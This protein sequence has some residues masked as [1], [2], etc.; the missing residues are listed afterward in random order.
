MILI[1]LCVLRDFVVQSDLLRSRLCVRISYAIAFLVAD[2]AVCRT[3]RGCPEC[4]ADSSPTTKGQ[5]AG[6]YGNPVIKT[7][8]LDALA[9][10]GDA[11][12]VCLLHHGQLQPQ[13]VGD[14]YRPVQSCER[15]V[16]PGA[17]RTS[18]SAASTNVKSLPV[19]LSAAGY[20]TARIGKFH[21]GPDSVYRFD[22][23]LPGNPRNPV[24][25]AERLP[26]I[27]RSASRTSRSFCT[28]AR[29]IRIAAAARPMRLPSDRT[30][31][32]TSRAAS[33]IR[34]SSRC[35]TSRRT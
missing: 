17:R 27:D 8:N 14:S 2:I 16:R 22:E 15:P 21:V 12:Q 19:L 4:G 28:S 18:L 1:S 11:V 6:C 33:R 26:R 32:A 7:P 25:M 20:R 31:S 30:A 24:A 35:I 10:D 34:A 9:A 3:H 13:P 29:P 23:A 5:D